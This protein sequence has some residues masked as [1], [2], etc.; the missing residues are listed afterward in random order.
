MSRLSVKGFG[1]PPLALALARSSTSSFTFIACFSETVPSVI[2]LRTPS[3]SAY[4][5]LREPVFL[6]M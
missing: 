1:E 4:W 5:M 3:V 6:T 2:V